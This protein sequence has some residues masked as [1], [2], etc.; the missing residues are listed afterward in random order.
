MMLEGQIE[1][2]MVVVDVQDLILNSSI[3]DEAT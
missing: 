3:F 1:G 2:N